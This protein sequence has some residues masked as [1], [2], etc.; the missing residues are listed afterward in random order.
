[1]PKLG[2]GY[3]ILG[4]YFQLRLGIALGSLLLPFVLW[5][6]GMWLEDLDLQPSLS[7]YYR[8][9]D[10]AMRDPFVGVLV[11]IGLSLVLYK[12]YHWLE[13]LLLNVCGIAAVGVAF[14]PVHEEYDWIPFGLDQYVH[15]FFAVVAFISAGIVAVFLSRESLKYIEDVKSIRYKILYWLYP[16]LGVMMVSVL[17]L[18]IILALAGV[19]ENGVFWMES[20]A[21]WLFAL[22]W[23]IKSWELFVTERR[24]GTVT[25][26]WIRE[27]VST[28]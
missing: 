9:G 26:E 4:T 13:N 20:V 24:L 14:V 6:G 5:L 8:E 3:S 18:T 28:P 7:D 25:I 1:M 19:I 15:G 21:V 22:Y 2:L 11:F 23:L 16:A 17:A 12:G 10:G 27:K